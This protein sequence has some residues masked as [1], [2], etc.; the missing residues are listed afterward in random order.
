MASF[1]TLPGR[2]A[3]AARLA[4][5]DTVG[6]AGDV[7]RFVNDKRQSGDRLPMRSLR[8]TAKLLND[9]QDSIKE[10]HGPAGDGVQP[11][12][13][14]RR[15]GHIGV[16]GRSRICRTR[17]AT[18][19]KLLNPGTLCPAPAVLEWQHKMAPTSSA[20]APDITTRPWR[21]RARCS[22]CCRSASGEQRQAFSVTSPGTRP[23]R[24]DPGLLLLTLTEPELQ[25][26]KL[27][28]DAD[29]RSRASRRGDPLTL[30]QQP[31][32][33]LSPRPA[34]AAEC[35]GLYRCCSRR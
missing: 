18:Q 24:K 27:V 25:T 2:R 12:Q 34:R 14:L 29:R 4:L 8:P 33:R 13:R 17:W 3:P 31:P 35:S 16:A 9:N 10:I 23:G 22:R 11:D 21:G 28:A 26:P 1:L 30:D 32:P 5:A 20:T 6:G 15:V 19:R 7:A